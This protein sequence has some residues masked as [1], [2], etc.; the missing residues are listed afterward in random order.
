MYEPTIEIGRKK[1]SLFRVLFIGIDTCK[2]V[3][4]R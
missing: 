1:L 3:K 2:Y 4:D